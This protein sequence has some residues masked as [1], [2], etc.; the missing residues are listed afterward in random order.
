MVTLTIA[1]RSLL[2]RKVRMVLIGLLVVLGTMLIVIGETF[3]LSV[4]QS[5]KSAIVN[6]FTGDLIIYSERAKDNPSPFSFTTPLPVVPDPHRIE[7]WLASHPM[8]EKHVA[9][10]QNYGLLSIEKQGNKYEVPFIFYA[11]DPKQYRAAFPNISVEEGRFYDTD[12]GGPEAGVVLSAF[13]KENYAKNYSV[14]VEPGDA[15]TLLSLSDGGSVNAVPSRLVGIYK[16]KYYTNVFNYINFLDIKSYARLYN[17]T[18]VDA[19]S[20]PESFNRALASESDDDI[21]GLAGSFESGLDTKN[22]VSRELSGYTMIVVKLKNP[23]DATAFTGEITRQNSGVKVATWSEASGFFAYISRIIQAVIYGA[24]FL[25]FLIVVFILM[26]TLIISVLER[27][28][29]IG[30]LRA[31]GAEKSFI[32]AVFLWESFLLNGAAALCGMVVSIVLVATIGGG[33]GILLPD[34]IQQYLTGGGGIRL[35]VTVRPFAEALAII[36]IVSLLATIYPIKV[37]TAVTPLK[38][39]TG[40]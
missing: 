6:Y 18:G 1:M 24:T 14:N 7:E 33:E 37:A 27:T 40:N 30:T 34:I 10:A 20:M 23:A 9:I 8:V 4:K 38:A 3:S 19:S 29:E 12:G 16:P 26:N 39:M 17:F 2:R 11:V 13:Q 36:I 25:I 35:L 32:T 31:M 28:G 22:L 15:V 5:S 21:F